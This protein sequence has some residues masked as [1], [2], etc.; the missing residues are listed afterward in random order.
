MPKA[1]YVLQRPIHPF[2]LPTCLPVACLQLSN[3]TPFLNLCQ[4]SS[5]SV[6]SSPPHQHHM[7][8]FEKAISKIFCFQCTLLNWELQIEQDKPVLE[9]G[10]SF[11]ELLLAII[12]CH[13]D[14]LFFKG[15][16]SKGF[17]R[18]LKK[19]KLLTKKRFKSST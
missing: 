16:H 1:I 18:T 17:P 5:C 4:R 6:T 14:I 19:L 11:L 2:L 15:Q 12:Q 10:K 9:L 3:G 8:L 7:P 13:L